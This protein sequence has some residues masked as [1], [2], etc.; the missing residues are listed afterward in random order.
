MEMSEFEDQDDVLDEPQEHPGHLG[1]VI[2]DEN[3]GLR[4]KV[5]PVLLVEKYSF[6]GFE[7]MNDQWTIARNIGFFFPF[8][9]KMPVFL[10]NAR[11]TKCPFAETTIQKRAFF[12]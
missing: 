9:R 6:S 7:W 8:R 5:E 2:N 12:Q 10:K 3:P 11:L 4:I 1:R